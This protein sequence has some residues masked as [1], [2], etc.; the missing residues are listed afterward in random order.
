MSLILD[1][2]QSGL[3]A[4]SRNCLKVRQRSSQAPGAEATTKIPPCTNYSRCCY[5][6]YDRQILTSSYHLIKTPSPQRGSVHLAKPKSCGWT[7]PAW[8]L[9]KEESVSERGLLLLK[10]HITGDNTKRDQ[11]VY[12]KGKQL[13]AD[14][15]I[16]KHAHR[17]ILRLTDPQCLTKWSLNY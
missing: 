12:R 15:Q 5:S 17:K 14:G 16:T 7:L 2:V 1:T 9:V 4:Q 8:D 3:L 6:E 10:P 13:T 11:R